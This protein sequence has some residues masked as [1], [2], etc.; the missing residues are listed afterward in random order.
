MLGGIKLD[1]YL[2]SVKTMVKNAKNS[3]L[4]IPEME[5]KVLEATSGENWGASS[6]QMREIARATHSYANFPIIMGTIWRRLD[7]ENKN[8]R[9]ILKAL[10]LLEFLMKNGSEQ[11]IREARVHVM[12]IQRLYEFTFIE[13][14][15][16]Y[17]QSVRD[18]SRAL[19]EFLHD[20]DRIHEEREKA[21]VTAAKFSESISSDSYYSRGGGYGN[22]GGYGGNSG[23]YGGSSGGGGGGGYSRDY[24]S[25]YKPRSRESDRYSDRNRDYDDDSSYRRN[26][27]RDYDRDEPPKTATRHIRAPSG[28]SPAPEPKKAAAPAVNFFELD[29]PAKPASASTDFFASFPPPGNTSAPAPAPAQTQQPALDFFA[30]APAPSNGHS[31]PLNGN[32]QQA[33]EDTE[34]AEF[35]KADAP[36][37]STMWGAHKKLFDL[38]NLA[39]PANANQLQAKKPLGGSLGQPVRPL[40]QPTVTPTPLGAGVPLGRGAPLGAGQ[41]LGVQPL[42]MQPLGM[43]PL[44]V[45]PMGVQP[46]GVQPMGVQPYGVPMGYAPGVV[47]AGYGVAAPMMYGGVAPGVVPAGYG[48]G[49]APVAYGGVRP[50]T[51]GYPVTRP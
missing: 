27:S 42:G 31:Q 29:E 9:H 45:Q 33:K 32:T 11:V 24:D 22:S 15:K 51:A 36:T 20:D 6:T 23:G 3:L 4:N 10:I 2:D 16:D 44:G 38:D 1:G 39:T 35:A 49:A 37:D 18:K 46:M 7:E 28:G 25:D 43:Q 34:W 50:P 26:N 13:N 30:S 8:W 17:G 12:E 21:R 41:P 40:G 48:V 19:H 47:P 5:A 14:D